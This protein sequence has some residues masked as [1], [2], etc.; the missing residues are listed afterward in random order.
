VTWIGLELD[1]ILLQNCGCKLK[2][3]ASWLKISGRIAKLPAAEETSFL[4]E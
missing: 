3:L 4:V 2:T 1:R